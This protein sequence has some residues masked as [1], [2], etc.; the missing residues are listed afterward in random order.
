MF[1]TSLIIV[2]LIGYSEQNSFTFNYFAIALLATDLEQLSVLGIDN[3]LVPISAALF[4]N[5]FVTNL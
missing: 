3:F 1:L 4:F 5:F 2:S